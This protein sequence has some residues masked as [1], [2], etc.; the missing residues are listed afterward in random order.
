MVDHFGSGICTKLGIPCSGAAP[1]E[2][3]MTLCQ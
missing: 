1:I 3:G 2:T